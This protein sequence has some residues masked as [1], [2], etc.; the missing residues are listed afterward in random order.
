MRR[1]EGFLLVLV[2]LGGIKGFSWIPLYFNAF[3]VLAGFIYF[4]CSFKL[5]RLFLFPYLL[6]IV[7]FVSSIILGIYGEV[8][9]RLLQLFFMIAVAHFLSE[10]DPQHLPRMIALLLVPIAALEFALEWTVLPTESTRIVLGFNVPRLDGLRIDANFNAMFYGFLGLVLLYGGHRRAAAIILFMSLFSVSRGTILALTMALLMYYLPSR[11]MLALVFWPF[12][13]GIVAMPVLVLTVDWLIN[14]TT[15]DL[16]FAVTTR[17][18]H[19]WM[20]FIEMGLRNPWTGVGYFQGQTFYAQY[21]FSEQTPAQQAHNLFFDVLGEF[22]ILGFI[23]LASFFIHIALLVYR[24]RPDILPLFAYIFTGFLFYNALSEWTLWVGVGFI[25]AKVNQVRWRP[26][27]SVFGSV[28][29]SRL[30]AKIDPMYG[31]N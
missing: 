12:V 13:I 11:R 1:V 20:T 23:F 7:G 29:N 27:N 18:Y 21:A 10:T 6:V 8:Q 5:S 17:R 22:G 9:L 25:L 2:V 4:I 15:R 31:R 30:P 26:T 14:E 28:K 19:H 24:T 16:L 3:A